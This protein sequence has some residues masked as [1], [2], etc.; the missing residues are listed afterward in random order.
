MNYLLDTN[1]WIRFFDDPEVINSKVRKI[2][3]N[4]PKFALS[5]FNII[6]VCQ[7]VSIGKLTPKRPLKDWLKRGTLP[8]FFQ[9]LPVT[10][11]IA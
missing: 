8:E 11:E 5:P 9:I 2:L 1:A 10:S 3:A 6:E 4:E 7:K